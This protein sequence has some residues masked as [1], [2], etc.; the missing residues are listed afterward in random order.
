[1]SA[2]LL[3]ATDVVA[4]AAKQEDSGAVIDETYTLICL[5]CNVKRP[6]SYMVHGDNLTEEDKKNGVR[7][8]KKTLL[9]EVTE[10]FG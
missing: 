9:E 6:T 10:F 7:L 5:Q 3:C 2:I 8:D 4:Q 1:M